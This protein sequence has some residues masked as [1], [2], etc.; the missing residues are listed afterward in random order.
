MEFDEEFS[1]KC[2]KYSILHEY[3]NSFR[4]LKVKVSLLN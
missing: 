1:A 3:I 2:D 4:V